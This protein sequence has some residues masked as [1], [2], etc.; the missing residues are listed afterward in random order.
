MINLNGANIW[1]LF[2]IG[3]GFMGVYCWMLTDRIST[4]IRTSKLWA[5]GWLGGLFILSTGAKLMMP[6]LD[7]LLSKTGAQDEDMIPW[8]FG[9]MIVLCV[10]VV[11]FQL[12]KLRRLRKGLY[13]A[14]LRRS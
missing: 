13:E 3:L 6:V 4:R 11:A 9:L 1:V 10:A 5:L 7:M 2:V 14:P 8:L 12:Y